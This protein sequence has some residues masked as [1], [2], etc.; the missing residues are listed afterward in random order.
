MRRPWNLVNSPVYALV[1]TNG[2]I[3][4]VNICTYAMA[5]SRK[6]KLY[7]VALEIGSKTLEFLKEYPRAVLQMLTDQHLDL[8]K[9][10]GQ[11]SGNRFDKMKYLNKRDQLETWKQWPILKGAAANLELESIACHPCGDHE[12]FIMKV[13]HFR[14]LSDHNIL[15][16]EHLMQHKLIL[17]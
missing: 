8:I 10:L 6:P 17:T 14:S 12:L 4:N 15:M 16:F 13:V 11:R 1:T 5:V 7:A 3:C 9:P 2:N